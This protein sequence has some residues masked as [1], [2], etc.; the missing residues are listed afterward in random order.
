MKERQ[1][2]EQRLDN[3]LAQYYPSFETGGQIWERMVGAALR[4][5]MRVLD[6]GA[7][8]NGLLYKKFPASGARRVGLDIMPLPARH[9]ADELVQGDLGALPVGDG[10]FDLVTS[11]FV[12]EHLADPL[13][14]FRE[15]RRALK[16]GGKFIFITSNVL[17]PIMAFS[18][19]T[20]H[21]I[22]AMLRDR[23]L[24]QPA[25]ETFPTTY[26]ANTS[27]DLRAL[28]RAAGFGEIALR[29]AGNPGYFTFSRALLRGAIAVEKLIDRPRL[30]WLK[31]YLVGC[32]TNPGAPQPPVAAE[33]A[34]GAVAP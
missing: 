29:R 14:A 24:A 6:A 1:A 4:P 17:N 19:L 8:E 11:E 27:A 15:I 30:E 16:P 32:F 13:A 20:P 34:A 22:H 3:Y 28:G 23:L 5:G 7:G 2:H 18:K 26:R 31:M 10:S 25:H 9:P 12:L 21:G 33:A